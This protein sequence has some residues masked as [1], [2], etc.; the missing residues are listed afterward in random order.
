M[1][2]AGREKELGDV[3]D[4]GSLTAPEVSPGGQRG[5]A[6]KK[7]GSLSTGG[8]WGGRGV[9]EAQPGPIFALAYRPTGFWVRG[10]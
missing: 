3:R 6:A 5:A 1:V 4:A 10:D 8:V 7:A 9:F 2:H